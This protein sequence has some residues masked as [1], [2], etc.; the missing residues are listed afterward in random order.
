[1]DRFS[2]PLYSERVSPD[3]WAEL[4][5]EQRQS[6]K[7]DIVNSYLSTYWNHH[8]ELPEAETIQNLFCHADIDLDMI[9][10]LIREF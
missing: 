1:M 2:S 6:N 7:R 3:L 4:I 5:E 8:Q 9:E 10:E